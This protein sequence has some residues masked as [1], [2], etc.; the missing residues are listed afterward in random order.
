MIAASAH[1]CCLKSIDVA[2]GRRK[3]QR[4]PKPTARVARFNPSLVAGTTVRAIT[5]RNEPVAVHFRQG[6]LDGACGVSCVSMVLAIL[7]LVKASALEAMAHRKHGIASDVWRAFQHSFFAGINAPELCEA[8][9]SLALRLRLTMR[10]AA[11]RTDVQAHRVVSEFAIAS[12][13][14]GSLVMLAYR[15]LRNRRHQHWM[16]ATGIG[17]FE[18]GRSVVY[19][20]I[21]VL[22][23]GADAIPLAVY[24]ATLQ[25]VQRSDAKHP[26]WNV[27]CAAGYLVPVTLVSAVRFD[28]A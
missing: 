12:L 24:N 14:R 15:S 10:H 22:D 19:D 1:Y 13:R 4:E 28:P 9:R 2:A 27:E 17:G 23:P 25:L 11:D 20:T 6:D 16:L 3:S 5:G 7:G 18:Y 8:V 21:Y 26:A